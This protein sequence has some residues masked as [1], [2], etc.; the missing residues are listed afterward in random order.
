MGEIGVLKFLSGTRWK[1]GADIY[2]IFPMILGSVYVTAGALAAGRADG[3]ADGDLSGVLLPEGAVSRRSSPRSS[4][5]R[6]IPSV[7]YGFF[8]IV[9]LVPAGARARRTMGRQRQLDAHGVDSA[10][11]YD[12]A[13]H[14]RRGRALRCAPCRQ[15]I[16]R[17]RWRWAQRTSAACYTAVC[18]RGEERHSGGRLCWAWAARWARRWPSSW[19]RATSRACPRASLQGVRTLTT[20]IVMEMGYAAGTAPRR[21]H[22][23]AA[24]CCSCSSCIINLSFSDAEEEVGKGMKC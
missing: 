12:S 21:A 6:G 15:A 20:N 14:H 3:A 4:C 2:G 16:T 18:A 11:D 1:P 9:V 7:V 5:W 23:H 17:A 8:G 24:L 13:D 10:G 22:R 19:W